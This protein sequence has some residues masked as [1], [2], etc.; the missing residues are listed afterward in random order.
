MSRKTIAQQASWI[1]SEPTYGRI[2]AV[3]EERSRMIIDKAIAVVEHRRDSNKL[4]AESARTPSA[5]IRASRYGKLE[6]DELIL[7]ELEEMRA[8][9]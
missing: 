7:E 4:S 9:L 5:V 3:L 2:V 1:A 8:A 6:E